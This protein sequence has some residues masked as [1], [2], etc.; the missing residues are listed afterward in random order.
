MFYKCEKFK[1]QGLEAW[2]PIKCKNMSCMFYKC[3]NFDCNL[4]NWDVKNVTD[5]RAMFSGCYKFKGIGLEN[6]NPVKLLKL[7]TK[8]ERLKGIFD[9]CDSLKEYPDWYTRIMN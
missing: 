7:K 9:E 6:W 8:E 2:K 4:S 1:G 5:M 3:D